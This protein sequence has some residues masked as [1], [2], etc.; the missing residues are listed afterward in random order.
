[1]IK[2]LLIKYRDGVI[3]VLLPLILT[4]I[5][6]NWIFTP[7]TNYMPDPWFYFA[8][9]RYFYNYAPVYPSNVHYFVERLTWNVPG[10][11][12]Y[13]IFPPLQ[14]NYI[15]HLSVYYV[16]VFSL[17]G[18]LNLI[19]NRRT[20]LMS[21]LLMGSYP[22]VLRAV[23]WDY[24]DG[25]GIA[26]MLL[27]IFVLTLAHFTANW[28]A[29][30]IVA[31][32]VH[33]SLIVTNLF[34]L[35]FFPGWAVYFI[36]INRK[37]GK[38]KLEQLILVIAYFLVG[39][40][41]TISLCGF[42]YY[43]VTGNYFFLENS[44]KSAVF[45]THDVRSINDTAINYGHLRPYWHVLPGIIAFVSTWK[46]CFSKRD[47]S[48]LP[49]IA[50]YFLFVYSYSLLIFWHSYSLPFLIVFPYSSYA[51]PASFLL[52]GGL[53]S[54]FFDSFSRQQFEVF[55]VLSG[56]LLILPFAVLRIFPTMENL[57]GNVYLVLVF[58]LALTGLLLVSKNRSSI[59]IS[60][61]VLI[62]LFYL[63]AENAY[64]FLPNPW[65]GRDNFMG[66]VSASQI[67]DSYYPN[68]NYQDF[69]LWFRSDKNYDTFFSLACL[70][71]YPWGSALG[72]PFSSRKPATELTLVERDILQEGDKIVIV[73]SDS[74]RAAILEEANR[75]AARQHRKLEFETSK[76]IEQGSLKFF[77][78][79]TKVSVIN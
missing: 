57:Q 15:L 39:S 36:L 9:F 21:A 60:G 55:A 19:F 35:A 17:F 47:K 29:C 78:Y 48:T 69:R 61:L 58:S 76:T 3:L 77:L 40:L 41:F 12:L 33:S 4:S 20:A 54:S 1:M 73:S 24:V 13:K 46:L 79:F 45:L 10:F 56:I 64:V 52:F 25:T 11:Y 38:F 2:Q 70:Y 72:E 7:V 51:L 18:T 44:L 53:L 59:L 31:G 16:A 71:L 30:F 32:I 26:H 6:S 37:T 5:N 22:W 34:W 28:R 50:V 66:I 42:F 65:Q 63:V 8:Y 43:W 75:S 62:V 74:A 14:A 27:L 49:F 67:L 68:H 23:G